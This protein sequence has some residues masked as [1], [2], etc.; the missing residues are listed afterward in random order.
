LD[1]ESTVSALETAVSKAA[2]IQIGALY[3][4][5]LRLYSKEEI[6]PELLHNI[7]VFCVRL[8]FCLYAEDSLVFSRK[9]MFGN[10]LKAFNGDRYEFR[11]HLKYHAKNFARF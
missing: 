5:I 6:T 3:N 4:D 9:D 7:N 10:Y 2:A 8:V 1:K 11:L